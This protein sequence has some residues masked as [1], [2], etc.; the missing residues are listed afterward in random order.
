MMRYE[1]HIRIYYFVAS[2]SN[3]WKIH[4]NSLSFLLFFNI[5]FIVWWEHI[6]VSTVSKNVL[7]AYTLFFSHLY[8]IQN[9]S[10]IYFSLRTIFIRSSSD[11]MNIF[12]IFHYIQNPFIHIVLILMQLLTIFFMALSYI[13]SIIVLK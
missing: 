8:F 10:F 11:E 13:K 12:F 7:D 1:I 2:N 5:S 6:V 9:R 4:N 3:Q